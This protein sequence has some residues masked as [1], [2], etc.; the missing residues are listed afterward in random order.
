GGRLCVWAEW[1]SAVH[2]IQ[3]PDAAGLFGHGHHEFVLG[4]RK[5]HRR[6]P[7]WNHQSGAFKFRH[8]KRL[9]NRLSRVRI[10]VDSPDIEETAAPREKVNCP[11]IW[12]PARLIVPVLAVSNSCPPATRH[13]YCVERGFRIG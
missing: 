9:P 13:G 12:R 5:P 8:L 4:E 2:V 6:Y 1:T 11:A 7:A 10:E 3:H